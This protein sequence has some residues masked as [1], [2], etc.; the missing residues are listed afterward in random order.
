GQITRKQGK[1]YLRYRDFSRGLEG[2]KTVIKIDPH[3]QRVFLLRSRPRQLRQVFRKNNRHQEYYQTPAGK[4]EMETETSGLE[5]KTNIDRG[6]INIDYRLYFNGSLNSRNNLYIIY[7]KK[8]A[9][10]SRE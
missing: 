9:D 2:V 8:G 10:H 4:L 5:I 3:Q 7:S 1:Y 6:V